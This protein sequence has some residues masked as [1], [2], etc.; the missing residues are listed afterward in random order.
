MSEASDWAVRNALQN[1]ESFQ[2]EYAGVQCIANT[3]WIFFA[4]VDVPAGKAAQSN[5]ARHLG[6]NKVF[7]NC[8]GN[9]WYQEGVPGI[10]SDLTGVL[11]WLSDLVSETSASEIKLVGHSMGAYACLAARGWLG[12]GT[13]IA[14]SPELELDHPH[15]RSVRNNVRTD[16]NFKSLYDLLEQRDYTGQGVTVFGAYDAVDS[17]FLAD[18][19]TYDGRFGEI[20]VCPYHHGVTEFFTARRQYHHLLTKPFEAMD[21]MVS[22]GLALPVTAADRQCYRDFYSLALAC[23]RQDRQSLGT[24]LSSHDDWD[25]AGWHL[26][27]AHGFRI[28]GRKDHALNAA[29]MAAAICPKAHEYLIGYARYAKLA[30]AMSEHEQALDLMQENLPQHTLIRNYL[31]EHDRVAAE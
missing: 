18:E 15:S 1:R 7:L 14:T 31:A 13:F 30:G 28:M 29:R 10:A 27:S 11:S 9:S 5:V 26:E 3:L 4:H 8:P 24:L 17:L 21:S 6:G 23:S 12:E 16:R 25:N 22:S 2:G 20:L 19:R